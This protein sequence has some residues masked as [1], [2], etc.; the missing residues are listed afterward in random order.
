MVSE[1]GETAIGLAVLLLKELEADE[2]IVQQ[3]IQRVQQEFILNSHGAALI[4][5]K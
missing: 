1:E 3:E 2:K 4:F 5:E